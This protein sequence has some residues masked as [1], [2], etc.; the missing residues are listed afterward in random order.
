MRK[1]DLMDKLKCLYRMKHKAS[2]RRITKIEREVGKVKSELNKIIG[3]EIWK[4]THSNF[5]KSF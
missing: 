2:N 3:E 1:H 4:K 5:Q